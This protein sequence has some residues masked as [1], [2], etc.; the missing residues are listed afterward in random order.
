MEIF[1]YSNAHAN[2]KKWIFHIQYL[3][4]R[5]QV[6]IRIQV[7]FPELENPKNPRIQP[8][9][10]EFLSNF[11]GKRRGKT[12]KGIKTGLKLLKN[13]RD[14]GGR[15]LKDILN[16]KLAYIPAKRFSKWE[17]EDI[18]MILKAEE[19]FKHQPGL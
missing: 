3:G 5:F 18:R 1:S 17:E 12:M 6:D 15:T 7:S 9:Y 11:D 10:I 14:S 19:C 8:K 16:K 2:S 4:N 13:A